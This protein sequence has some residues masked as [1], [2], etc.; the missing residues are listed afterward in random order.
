MSDTH[1]SVRI[2]RVRRGRYRATNG[3]GATLEFGDDPAA[4]FTPVQLMLAAMAGCTAIDV[5]W[6]IT[7]KRSE[8]LQ[9]EVEGAGEK[10]S[11]DTGHR[12]T[13]LT[14]TFR[15]TF[16]DDEAGRA[17]PLPPAGRHH[18]LA[19]PP[20]HRQPH[21]RS[22]HPGGQPPRRLSRNPPWQRR[23]PLRNS[24]RCSPHPRSLP[25]ASVGTA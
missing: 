9:F 16:P 23:R 8:P 6:I 17:A 2:E 7:T 15:V 12:M 19:R 24:N 3:E 10:L 14:V 4:T 21:H 11:D 13:D 25:P 1:R 18:A 5:D 22:R 20:V